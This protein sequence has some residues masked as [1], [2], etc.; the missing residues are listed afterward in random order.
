MRKSILSSIPERI[1]ME[2]E[3]LRLAA[4]KSNVVPL[5]FVHRSLGDVVLA[6][7]YIETSKFSEVIN[8][9]T[10]TSLVYS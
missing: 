7:P 6:M 9:F 4:G 1:W 5:L 10:F 2:V 8:N 3:C